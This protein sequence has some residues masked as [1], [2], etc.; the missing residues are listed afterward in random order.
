M[1]YIS[2]GIICKGKSEDGLYIRHFGQP[3][4]IFKE[5]AIMWK[6]AQY[7]FGDVLTPK[8][9]DAVDLLVKKGIAVIVNGYGDLGKYHALCRCAICANPKKKFRLIPLKK[10]EKILLI[11]LRK[12]GTNLTLPELVCLQDKG[13]KPRRELFYRENAVALIRLIYPW[14]V[15]LAGELESRMKHSI[16]RKRTVDSILELLRKKLIVIM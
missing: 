16:A 2:K 14:C 5:Q 9:L 6:R 12:A 1:M 13:V 11:W 7:G 4:E 3:M 15:S 8:E 10:E